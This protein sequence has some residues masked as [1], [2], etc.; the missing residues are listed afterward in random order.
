MTIT[1]LKRQLK[2]KSAELTPVEKKVVEQKIA[3]LEKLSAE[4]RAR[5]SSYIGG[6]NIPQNG[7]TFFNISAN[8]D[9]TSY[10]MLEFVN[11]RKVWGLGIINSSS[12]DVF[13]FFY[14][15]GRKAKN[16]EYIFFESLSFS[17]KIIRKFIKKAKNEYLRRSKNSEL[18]SWN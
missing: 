12:K 10:D 9:I 7:Q 4:L 3:T 8:N 5:E 16:G 17:E 18:E 2:K 15:D 1:V 13:Y 6:H 11:A 14:T